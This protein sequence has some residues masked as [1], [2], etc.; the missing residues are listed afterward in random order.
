MSIFGKKN[1]SLDDTFI[2]KKGKAANSEVEVIDLDEELA[3]DGMRSASQSSFLIVQFK[4]LL[5]NIRRRKEERL[6]LM[7]IPHNEK[8]IKN[9]YVSNLT[10]NL[11]VGVLSIII[12]ISSIL[13]INHTSTIQ[14]VDKL[15]ISQEDAQIQFNKIKEEIVGISKTY[16]QLKNYLSSLYESTGRKSSYNHSKGGNTM[17]NFL[18][19]DNNS[20]QS[21]LMPSSKDIQ[22]I[23]DI[24]QEIFILNAILGDMQN[25]EKP[26]AEV[27]KFLAKRKNVI[28][29][30]PTLWPVHGSIINPFGHIRNALTLEKEFNRGVHIAAAPNSEVLVSAPGLVT[31]VVKEGQ[32][33]WKVKVRHKY[34][35]VTVY[36]GLERVTVSFEEELS[37][38]DRLG[39]L[40]RPGNYFESILKYEI[41][42]GTEPQNP[43]PYLGYIGD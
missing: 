3:L 33:G 16:G 18:D 4:K 17:A 8:S 10:L 23:E 15:K 2:R 30:S 1:K 37:K 14:E 11:A 7:F 26:L 27:H 29:N 40:G 28:K 39:F 31:S 22:N 9:V 25:S 24:P 5:K 12:I 35:Y 32:W 13:I 43:I 19:K 6:T 20:N 42:V 21:G 36:K 41:Y 38:G 34:G